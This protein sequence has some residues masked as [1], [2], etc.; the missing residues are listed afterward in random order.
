[1]PLFLSSVVTLGLALLLV[2]WGPWGARFQLIALLPVLACIASTLSALTGRVLQVVGTLVIA[3]SV[4]LVPFA[5]FQNASK[6]LV[7]GS[8]DLTSYRAQSHDSQYFRW[9]PSALKVY[10]SA[11]AEVHHDHQH[12]I[13][14]VSDWFGGFL[15]PLW[16]LLSERSHGALVQVVPVAIDN[17]SGRDTRSAGSEPR[18][19]LVLSQTASLESSNAQR[20]LRLGYREQSVTRT[21]CEFVGL[22]VGK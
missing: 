21:E 12:E 8:G 17:R 9:C 7:G 13:G 11:I 6:P 18:V 1:V 15:Y 22:Y 3:G 10:D 16:A 19:T 20:L 2:R 14:Y 4:I 5:L